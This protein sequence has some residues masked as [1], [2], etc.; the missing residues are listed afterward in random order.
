M[1]RDV[2]K[3]ILSA[4]PH[5]RPH[6]ASA[7]CWAATRYCA[8]ARVLLSRAAQEMV[9]GALLQRCPGQLLLLHSAWCINAGRAVWNAGLFSE[10]QSLGAMI[11]LSIAAAKAGFARRQTLLFLSSS[12]RKPACHLAALRG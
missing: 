1:Y 9:V 4:C 8:N 5:W 7:D 2:T 10:P 6:R 11:G 3:T 12:P